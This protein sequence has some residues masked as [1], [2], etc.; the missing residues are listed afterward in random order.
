MLDSIR[1]VCFFFDTI[2][3]T[4]YPRQGICNDAY[5]HSTNTPTRFQCR[6]FCADNGKGFYS[7]KGNSGD[8]RCRAFDTYC[9]EEFRLQITGNDYVT[10]RVETM[11]M[12]PD[13][14]CTYVD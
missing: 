3:S 10:S 13:I 9:P 5:S 1:S 8:C 4:G 12:S 2:F 14:F 7:Y 11:G 6:N